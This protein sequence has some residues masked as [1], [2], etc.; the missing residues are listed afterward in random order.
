MKIVIMTDD[1]SF[2]KL[3]AHADVKKWLTWYL[4]GDRDYSR[5]NVPGF[6]I[7]EMFSVSHYPHVS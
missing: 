7:S 5:E 2:R 4:M 6:I 1:E 3:M